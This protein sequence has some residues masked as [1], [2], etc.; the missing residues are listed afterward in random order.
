MLPSID[1]IGYTYRGEGEVETCSET[2]TTPAGALTEVTSH[3]YDGLERRT[4]TQRY[5]GY[6]TTYGYVSRLAPSDRTQFGQTA[7]GSAL[8]REAV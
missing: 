2:K 8:V 1:A 3:F 7:P 6:E 5:D 4:R